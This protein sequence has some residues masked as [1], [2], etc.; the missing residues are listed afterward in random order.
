MKICS[1]LVSKTVIM[2][3]RHLACL[4]CVLLMCSCLLFEFSFPLRLVLIEHEQLSTN[5]DHDVNI[6]GHVNVMK[7]PVP[8]VR[9]LLIET[10]FS[11]QNN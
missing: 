5:F 7:G 4:R 9:T 1:V 3:V 6:M 10:A 8:G 11:G 2:W